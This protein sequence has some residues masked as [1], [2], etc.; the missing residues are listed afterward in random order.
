[1][2]VYEPKKKNNPSPLTPQKKP[3]TPKIFMD[4]Q[5]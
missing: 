1:M 4:T 5:Q 2:S 3:Q